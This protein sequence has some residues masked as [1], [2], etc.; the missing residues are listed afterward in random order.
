[1]TDLKTLLD[2]AAGPDP[3]LTDDDLLGDLRRG[4]RSARRRQLAGVGGGATV[5]AVMAVGA[6]AVLPGA[7]DTGLGSGPAGQPAPPA[8]AVLP[9]SVPTTAKSGPPDRTHPPVQAPAPAT[10]VKLVPDGVVRPGT[11]LVCGLKPEGWE[12]VVYKSSKIASSSLVFQNPELDPTKYDESS[13]RLTVRHA[14][15]WNE[16]GQLLVEKY[17]QTWESLPHVMAGSRQAVA[18][19]SDLPKAITSRDVHMRMGPTQL[20][21]TTGPRALGWD[22]P[23]LLRFTA[24]C[25]FAK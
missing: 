5:L 4:K 15:I 18:T 22:L 10:P 3:I 19:L 6:W 1:M 12:P 11:D 14:K 17:G 8:N 16:N 25:S 21:Q 20:L 24:S 23:T 2:Q 9:S 13:T 7:H